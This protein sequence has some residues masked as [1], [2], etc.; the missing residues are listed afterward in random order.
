MAITIEDLSPTAL[1][2]RTHVVP[3]MKDGIT[4]KLTVGQI[5]DL[6][7]DAA[8]GALDTLNELAAALGD[9]PN[10]AA[11]TAALI[12][13]KLDK[14]GGNALDLTLSPSAAPTKKLAFSLAAITAGQTRTITMPDTDVDLKKVG[15]NAMAAQIA[16]GVETAL[17]F[18]S[19]PAGVKRITVSFVNFST[20]GT[21]NPVVQLGTSGGYAATGYVGSASNVTGSSVTSSNLSAGFRTQNSVIA[22]TTFQGQMIITRVAGN[23][24]ACVSTVGSS[25]TT[26]TGLCGGYIAL[27]GE[28]DRLR[29]TTEGGSNTIDNGSIVNVL[30]EF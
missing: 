9:D 30:Y 7:I 25:D 23:S 11:T 13:A 16:T 6:V 29:M 26:A 1:P 20:N 5:L 17:S 24:W 15:I 22:A 12:A 2:S 8:P 27:V 18:P 10:F 21:S 28:L 3:A 14:S 19:I 4:V